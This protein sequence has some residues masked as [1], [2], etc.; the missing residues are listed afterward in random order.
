MF[1]LH[2]RSPLSHSPEPI[3]RW[4]LR[5]GTQL[6]LRPM[7]VQDGPLLDDMLD[8]LSAKTRRNRF[9]GGINSHPSLLEPCD[10]PGRVAFVVTAERRQVLQVVAEARYAIDTQGDS[11]EFAVVVDDRW[12]RH[13]LGERAM[14]ALS[15]T[16]A[17][18]GLHWLHGEVLAD[19]RAMLALMRRCRF[20]CTQ[21]QEDPQ[22]VHAE[23][24]LRR[25]AMLEA[26][27]A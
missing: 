13:G 15:N 2:T 8:R 21:D 24:A 25:P 1:T 27:R 3:D 7:R 16:A 18:T 12:Q 10:M 19:N 26:R 6:T 22:L 23:S 17:H 5:D 11:A 20:C 4:R 9:H 14:R